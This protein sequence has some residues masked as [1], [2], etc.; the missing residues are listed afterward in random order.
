MFGQPQAATTAT[1][2]PSSGFSFGSTA[3]KPA[4]TTPSFNF[5][6][7]ATTATPTFGTGQ[8]AAATATA[9]SLFAPTTQAATNAVPTFGVGATDASKP[10]GTSSFNFNLG[11]TSATATA[12]KPTTFNLGGLGGSTAPSGGVVGLGTSTAMPSTPAASLT[13]SI[14]ANAYGSNPILQPKETTGAEKEASM[15][16]SAR[17]IPTAGAATENGKTSTKKPI[18]VGHHRMFQTPQR[19]MR[20]KPRIGTTPGTS[21]PAQASALRDGGM[22]NTDQFQTRRSIKKL[23]IAKSDKFVRISCTL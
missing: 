19:D 16:A 11:G 21:T 6:P 12:V 4:T 18:P 7:S 22:F 1:A 17:M 20:L 8:P 14:N 10:T 13:A 2:A 3:A 9:P 5:G 15:R 23:D